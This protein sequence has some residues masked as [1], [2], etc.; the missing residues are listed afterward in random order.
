MKRM[1][2][3]F[4]AFLL[5]GSPDVLAQLTTATMSGTIKD[6]SGGVLP[7]VAVTIK[8]VETGIARSVVT[9]ADGR[10]EAA[11][12]PLG[13]YEVRAELSG[14]RPLVRSGIAL[15][16][17]RHAVVDLALEV[18]GMQEAVTVVSEAALLETNT[19]TVANLIDSKRVEELP[20]NNRDLTQLTYLQPGIV[21]MPRTGGGVFSGMGDTISVGGSRGNQNLYLLDGVASSDISGNPQSAMGAYVGAETIQEFQIITNNYSAE[22]RSQSGG[23]ISAVTKSGTNLLRGS[24]FWTHRNDSLDSA[25]Y[26]DEAFDVQKPDFSRHQ[27]GGSVGGPIMRNRSFF[28]ASYEGL[29]ERLGLTDTITV[30]TMLAR[31]GILPTGVV[32]I[33]PR[34]QPYVNLWPEPGNGNTVVRDNGDGTVQIAGLENRPTDGN[35]FLGKVD[36][37]LGGWGRLAVTYNYD[38]AER[39]IAGMRETVGA[40][41]SGAGDGLADASTKHVFSAK[42][43]RIWGSLVN[44]LSVG[45]SSTKPEGSIPFNPREFDNLPF[46]PQREL[47]GEL[48]VDGVASLGYRTILDAYGQY[49]YTV[50]NA[51]SWNRGKHSVRF[52]GEI[53]PMNLTQESCAR[54][55]NGV[56]SFEGWEEFLRGTPQTFEATL[57]QGDTPNRDLTQYLFGAYI[58]DNWALRPDFTFNLGVRYEYMTVPKEKN[59]NTGSL[60]RLLGHDGDDRAALQECHGQERQSAARVCVG[61]GSVSQDLCARW[62]RDLLRA[63]EPL[64]RAYHDAGAAAVYASGVCEPE[65]SQRAA[66]ISRRLQ[67]A[68]RSAQSDGE[69]PLADVRHGH[70]AWLPVEPDV[71]A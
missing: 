58:Q 63:P 7:G 16:V 61:S 27:Q 9:D 54:G 12:L 19:A 64:P 60:H 14:F 42:H 69:H 71:S 51:V 43:T 20:L 49:I 68:A 52:G 15:T 41:T 11:S 24:A 23:I 2:F 57:P 56:Y 31:Q 38:A 17:G 45:Y 29:R 50:Q 70:H 66:A 37:E 36:H 6:S 25:N 5:I 40:A 10:Y 59:G 34:V 32:P 28:F 21:K 30:P 22:Y 26:F 44:E 65:R 39:Q 67:H 8:H 55:C 4:V 35:Y 3:A 18:G 47:L 62:L 33:N 1:L 46:L 48:G 53:N 13:D